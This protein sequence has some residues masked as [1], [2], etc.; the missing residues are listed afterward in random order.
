MSTT[1]EFT[2]S[3]TKARANGNHVSWAAWGVILVAVLAVGES[4][5]YIVT[6]PQEP[7]LAVLPAI[8]PAKATQAAA[9][10]EAPAPTTGHRAGR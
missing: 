5:V 4:L 3:R 2:K 10:P 7:S 6:A 1:F 9:V 8:K